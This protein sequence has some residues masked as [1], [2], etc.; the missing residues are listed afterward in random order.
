MAPTTPAIT[1]AMPTSTLPPALVPEGEAA[2]ALGDADVPPAAAVPEDWPN[3][4]LGSAKL[5]HDLVMIGPSPRSLEIEA[6]QRHRNDLPMPSARRRV[7]AIPMAHMPRTSPLA[8]RARRGRRRSRATR[9]TRRTCTGTGVV[10]VV[11]IVLVGVPGSGGRRVFTVPVIAVPFALALS[12]WAGGSGSSGCTGSG[13]GGVVIV[14]VVVR[15]RGRRRGCA[16]L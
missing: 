6:G 16:V 7:L 14:P 13:F 2:G 5:T 12:R 9:T 11:V 8:R 4:D 1:A 10:V 3:A 15:V